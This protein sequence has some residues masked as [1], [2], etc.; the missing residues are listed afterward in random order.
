MLILNQYYLNRKIQS[1]HKSKTNMIWEIR[2]KKI[3]AAIKSAIPDSKGEKIA[4]QKE[5]QLQ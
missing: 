3:F 2:M 1:S 5:T 4:T